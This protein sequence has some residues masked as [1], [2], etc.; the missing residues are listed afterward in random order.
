MGGEVL[1]VCKNGR[2]TIPPICHL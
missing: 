2:S 1:P